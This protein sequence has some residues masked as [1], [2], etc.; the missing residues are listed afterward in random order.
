MN[1][2]AQFGEVPK[3]VKPELTECCWCPPDSKY[4]SDIG[5]LSATSPCRVN[6]EPGGRHC[7][8][9]SVVGHSCTFVK[10]RSSGGAAFSCSVSALTV[11]DGNTTR[12][13]APPTDLL[14][15]CVTQQ[16]ARSFGDPVDAT[17]P[18]DPNRFH[19]VQPSR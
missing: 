15:P 7:E 18:K 6:P 12:Q 3:P 10:I 17:D 13:L 9:I 8:A 11:Q 4:P 1:R 16:L 19:P 2:N 14:T 5:P